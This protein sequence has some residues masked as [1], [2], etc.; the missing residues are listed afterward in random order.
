MR[1]FIFEDTHMEK[2]E[3][4]IFNESGEELWGE[5]WIPLGLQ[6]APV[7]IMAH[8]FNGDRGESKKN[9]LFDFLR[10]RFVTQGIGVCQFDFSG[11]GQSSGK[12]I[13][14]SITK[15][16]QDLQSVI[17]AIKNRPDVDH[18][19]VG[20]LGLSMGSL[21]TLAHG[22]AGIKTMILMSAFNDTHNTFQK[23]F[24]TEGRY[25]ENG[26]SY[27]AC[28]KKKYEVNAS[29]WHDLAKYSF[30]DIVKSIF[31]PIL[32]IQAQDDAL[33]SPEEMNC[34]YESASGPKG[35]KIIQN[36][37]HDFDGEAERIDLANE[38]LEWLSEHL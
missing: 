25:D 32:F 34:L 28:G 7:I 29:F 22:G 16:A 24:T 33:I 5:L 10:D 30:K 8:A 37:G 3:L 27:I 20:V 35:I 1:V 18:E 14:T 6:K 9:N 23:M 31:V 17:D 15:R 21:A 19:R 11:C 12:F 38:I 13:H 26:I 2:Q 4:I 36:T